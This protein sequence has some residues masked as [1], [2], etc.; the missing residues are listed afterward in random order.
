VA[1]TYR[2]SNQYKSKIYDKANV[3]EYVGYNT[4]QLTAKSYE[5]IDAAN[6]P[7]NILEGLEKLKDTKFKDKNKL[8]ETI[9][10]VVGT[11]NTNRYVTRIM[12]RIEEHNPVDYISW[13]GELFMRGLQMVIVPLVLTS[14]I[15]GVTNIG[16]AEN[17][18]RLG[19]KTFT[20]YITTSLLAIVTGLFF[21]NMLEPGVGA[22][23]GLSQSVD[24]L[25]V[26]QE[27]FGQTM[28]KIVPINIFQAF[29]EGDMLA[30]IFFALLFGYYITRVNKKS[31]IL[32]IDIF[33]SAFDV[34]M[35][36][37]MFI[38]KFTPLGI[39]GI[40][41]K[42]VSEQAS[43]LGQLAEL[44]G[45]MG[46]YMVTVLV[47]LFVHSVI[48]LPLLVKILGKANPKLHFKAMRSA[49]FT[50]FSTSSSGATLS[51]TMNC[52]ENGAGVSNKI[53]S[54]VLPL[55]ATVNM[56]GTALYECVA[57]MFIA[58]AYGID[59]SV[60]EQI[61]VVITALLA[62][63]GAAS[64]P[65]A[66]LVMISIVLSAVGLPLEGI[67]LILAVDRFLDMFRTSIN[68]WSDTCGAV[69]IA[70]SEGETLKV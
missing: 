56:D 62:S 16:N 12:D 2:F 58:Q 60:T 8:E 4:W 40:V 42:V 1:Y 41:S 30:V 53:S 57:A 10:T 70:K 28:L 54:F 51:L 6:I 32:L 63:I 27:S 21:V 19:L 24:N 18:G 22:D 5:E 66:G 11:Y 38:I 49:L 25:G 13:M 61:I 65:M 47:G 15:T 34:M 7:A 50:A 69:I 55:G 29:S 31:S 9:T 14:I 37:T 68:V 33:N 20:Y 17:L 39:L 36:L 45:N 44:A 52:V 23:L 48:S 67:G 3:A 26:A 64:I 43:D 35:A 46:W 59:L